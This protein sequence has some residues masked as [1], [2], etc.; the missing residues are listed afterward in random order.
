M[1]SLLDQIT[2]NALPSGS[3]RMSI[4]RKPFLEKETKAQVILLE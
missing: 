1:S 2:A 4:G 3:M